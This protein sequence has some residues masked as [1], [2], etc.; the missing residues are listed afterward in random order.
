MT[1]VAYSADGLRIVSG[2]EDKKVRV[3]GAETG[4]QIGQPLD[5]HTAQIN[6]VA[7]SPD[8]RRIVSGSDDSAVRV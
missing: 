6:S 2:S 4:E 1:S 8:G 7:F 3:W 5:G